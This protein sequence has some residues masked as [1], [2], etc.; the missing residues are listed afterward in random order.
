[1]LVQ[2]REELD[3]SIRVEFWDDRIIFTEYPKCP[4]DQV[5][6]LFQD[7]FAEQMNMPYARQFR[8][9]VTDLATGLFPLIPA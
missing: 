7:E 5:S 6:G 1:M 4:H 3:S 8:R 9:F 2:W